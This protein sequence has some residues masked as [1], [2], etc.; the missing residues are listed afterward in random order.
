MPSQAVAAFLQKS[1]F[2]TRPTLRVSKRK[3]SSQFPRKT[4]H[5]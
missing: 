5:F 1:Q 3:I 4:P 2:S